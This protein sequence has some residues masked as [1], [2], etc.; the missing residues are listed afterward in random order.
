[1]TKEK[2][3]WD[4]IPSLEGLKV[5]WEY[6][7]ESPLGKRVRDRMAAK[8]LH[9]LFGV[10]NIPMKVVSKNFDEKG[11]LIDI[12]NGGGAI[13][14]GKSLVEGQL[15]KI[16]FFL[17]KQK[18]V[19]RAVVRNIVPTKTGRYRTGIEFI[20]LSEDSEVCIGSLIS[21]RGY[22]DY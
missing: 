19:E 4:S 20:E 15:V 21:A 6:E 14:L 9:M 22:T 1:M 7:A 8:E 3:G 2:T 12:S 16:G 13:L 5:E 11:Y 17:G 10:K 18:I